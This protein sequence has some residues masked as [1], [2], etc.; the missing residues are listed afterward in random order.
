MYYKRKRVFDLVQKSGIKY[1]LIISTRPDILCSKTDLSSFGG[2]NPEDFDMNLLNLPPSDGM[3][4]NCTEHR[5]SG[6][7]IGGYGSFGGYTDIFAAGS[8]QKMSIFSSVYDYIVSYVSR[9]CP[10]QAERLLMTHILTNELEAREVQANFGI[11]R[12][13]KYEDR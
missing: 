12:D 1:D 2:L 10:L 3:K 13:K 6:K 9:G 11:L 4:L 7:L 8:P 5:P